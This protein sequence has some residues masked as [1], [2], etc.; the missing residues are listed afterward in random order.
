MMKNH[1]IEEDNA[2]ASNNQ[3]RNHE[4]YIECEP[5]KQEQPSDHEPSKQEQPSY[6]RPDYEPDTPPIPSFQAVMTVR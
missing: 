2:R 6:Q 1:S 5:S 3:N 4:H